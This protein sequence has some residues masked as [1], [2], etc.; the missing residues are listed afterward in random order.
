MVKEN[1]AQKFLRERK[2]KEE[3]KKL[4]ERQRKIREA[5]KRAE[6]GAILNKSR[7]MVRIDY[8]K[9]MDMNGPFPTNPAVYKLVNMRTEEVFV[10]NSK[11]LS[12]GVK[13]HLSN[14]R[15]RCHVNPDLQE[16]YNNGDRFY[17]VILREYSYYDMKVINKDT[18]EYI[19]YENSYRRGY[20]RYIGGGFNP[21]ENNPNHDPGRR[22]DGSL[23]SP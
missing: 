7:D 14:L 11:N 2:E 8:S 23:S 21:Y 3:K 5:K 10:S 16:D 13:R 22:L 4:R 1:P 12:D 9:P 20:N 15:G 6:R 18:Q 17:V 19:E